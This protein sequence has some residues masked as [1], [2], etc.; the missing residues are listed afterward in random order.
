M[1][2]ETTYHG[3]RVAFDHTDDP[4]SWDEPPL[5][6]VVLDTMVWE[7]VQA[8][9]DWDM[10]DGD[11]CGLVQLWLKGEVPAHGKPLGPVAY[12]IVQEA[13]E[14]AEWEPLLDA[15]SDNGLGVAL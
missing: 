11:G 12:A 15:A 1:L 13:L 6:D 8:F 10:A 14:R 7:D 4:G 5:R 2:T 9:A 3:V